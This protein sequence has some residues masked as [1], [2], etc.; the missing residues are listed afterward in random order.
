VCVFFSVLR[1]V[2]RC[3]DAA[4]MRRESCASAALR[5]AGPKRHQLR[6]QVT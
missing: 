1:E 2:Y 3:P 4:A 5:Q 6:R